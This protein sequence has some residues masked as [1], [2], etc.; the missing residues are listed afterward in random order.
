MSIKNRGNYKQP[1]GDI[2]TILNKLGISFKVASGGNEL[3]LN[4]ILPDCPNPKN[5]LYINKKTGL[6]IK[7]N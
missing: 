1:K 5:H 7:P 4:C 6:L 2:A 3:V